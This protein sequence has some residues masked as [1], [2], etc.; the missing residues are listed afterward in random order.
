MCPDFVARNPLRSPAEG[1]LRPGVVQVGGTPRKRDEFVVDSGGL[2]ARFDYGGR[3]GVHGYPSVSPTQQAAFQELFREQLAAIQNQLAIYGWL[4]PAASLPPRLISGPYRPAAD[5]HVSV[6]EQY[7]KSEGL[8]PVWL[9]QRGWIEFPAY[10]VAAGQGAITH[11]LVHA[12]FPNGNRMLAEGLAV[13]LQFKLAP[14]IP[15]FPNFGFNLEIS[16]LDFMESSSKDKHNPTEALWLMDLGALEQIST[17]DELSLRI[18][19]DRPLGAQP[20]NMEPDP[21]EVKTIYAV[22]GSIVGMLLDAP[23]INDVF[24]AENFGAL[25]QETPLYPL[26]RECGAP[27][28][29]GKCYLGKDEQGNP[30][31]Y[32]FQEIGLLWKTYMH[33]LYETYVAGAAVPIP[34]G[35]YEDDDEA[36]VL[37]LYNKLHGFIAASSSTPTTNANAE[38]DTVTA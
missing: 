30:K 26:E 2:L 35:A 12:L 1:P 8:L 25:Y 22:V 17:P 10:R 32:S 6:S 38:K 5:F 27:E 7:N 37:D 36:L 21:E 4:S 13:Y 20:G 14:K 33:F 15:V 18:G 28:R 16:V 34:A 11:E 9:G 24:T 19:R 3:F 29:W 23:F 31:K